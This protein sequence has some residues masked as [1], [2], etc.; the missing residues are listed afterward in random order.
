ML[1]LD[2]YERSRECKRCGLSIRVT[3]SGHLRAHPCPHGSPCV[4]A[5]AARRRGERAGACLACAELRQL[6]LWGWARP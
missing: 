2:P 6:E 4:L 5:Y 3:S 1:A